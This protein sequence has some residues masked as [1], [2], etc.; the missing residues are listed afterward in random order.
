MSSALL[1]RTLVAVLGVAI[2]APAL[3]GPDFVSEDKF[4]P[5][6]ASDARRIQEPGDEILFALDDFALDSIAQAQLATVVRWLDGRPDV[7][8]VLEGHADSSGPVAY[9]A[10]LATERAEAVRDQLVARGVDA[11]RIVIAV[12]GENRARRFPA[13]HDRR[14]VMYAATAPLSRLISAELDRDAIEVRWTRQGTRL[15][16]TRGITPVAT[17]AS[18][19]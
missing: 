2:A 15:R 17:I 3:A 13:A 7:R 12:Y 1:S 18:R 9:N 8:L 14:V 19:R 16:E 6:A 4:Q 10:T 11:D 5:L